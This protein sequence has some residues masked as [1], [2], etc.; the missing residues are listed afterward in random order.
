M[1]N[2]PVVRLSTEYCED[3]DLTGKSKR[4]AIDTAAEAGLLEI[5]ERKTGRAPVVKLPQEW[6]DRI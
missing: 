4:R 6:E 2:S 1:R 3:F 5:V